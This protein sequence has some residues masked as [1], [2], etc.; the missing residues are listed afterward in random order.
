VVWTTLARLVSHAE[1][2]DLSPRSSWKNLLLDEYGDFVI[3]DLGLA[4]S[5]P[6]TDANPG[7]VCMSEGSQRLLIS[8]PAS[9]VIWCTC[10]EVIER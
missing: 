10:P 5:I 2:R 3:A 8:S 7:C 6:Y 4:L 9:V 1:V